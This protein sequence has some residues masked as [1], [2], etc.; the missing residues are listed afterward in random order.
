MESHHKPSWSE[1]I[2]AKFIPES[3][4]KEVGLSLI[5]PVFNDSERIGATLESVKR[6][7]FS[8]LEV[9]IVDAGSTDHTL[10]IVNSYQNLISRIYTVTDY[11]LYEML[12]RGIS[13]ASKR[14]TAFLFPGS[15]Y[16]S[17]TAFH[18][19]AHAI[20]EGDYPELLCSGA[21]QTETRRVPRQLLL[22]L[23]RSC[24]QRGIR[25]VV[26]AACWFRSDLFEI[27]GKFH[28]SFTQRSF[29]DFLCRFIQQDSFRVVQLDRVYVEYDAGRFSYGK[30]LK[31]ASDTWRILNIHFGLKWAFVWFLGVNHFNFVKWWFRNL[32]RRAFKG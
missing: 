19:M 32:E 1:K 10:E 16:L 15:F 18:V 12:N 6:Q 14:Y 3:L 25:P 20:G 22:P 24:L 2:I 29:F 4:K 23:E 28:S 7:N 21:I 31:Y 9:I 5:I 30:L 8:P 11:N 13:L 17:D 27:L 26:L